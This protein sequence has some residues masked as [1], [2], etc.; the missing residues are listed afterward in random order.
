MTKHLP[1]LLFIGLA[2]GTIIN[3]PADYSTIQE[4]INVSENADTILVQPGLYYENLNFIDK[5]IVIGSVFM[6]T[7]D[8]L[9]ITITII[10]GG[11]SG[12]VVDIRDGNSTPLPNNFIELNGFTIRNGN[13][14]D[15]SP[16][17]GGIFISMSYN[18]EDIVFLKNLN[19]INNKKQLPY[20]SSYSGGGGI[21]ISSSKVFMSNVLGLL[22]LI[23]GLSANAQNGVWKRLIHFPLKIKSKHLR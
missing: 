14:S 17:G 7:G 13:V 15:N 16:W 2:W 18:V 8:S 10:D 19:I 23:L 12:T 6:I 9:Y 3:I 11:D 20:N 22:I 21:S 4:G 5:N 1:L